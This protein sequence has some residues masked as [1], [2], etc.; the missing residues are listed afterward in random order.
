VAVE[1]SA[2][3]APHPIN[4][5]VLVVDDEPLVRWSLKERL[6]REGCRVLE[7]GT[8]RAAL[9]LADAA[10]DAMVLDYRLPDATG[11]GVLQAVTTLY[12]ETQVILMTAYSTLENAADAVAL[13]A[14]DYV[15]KPFDVDAVAGMVREAVALRRLLQE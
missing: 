5:T 10:V 14:F 9:A 13:G 6:T 11:L 8:A 3:G 2:P 15:A 1:K 7:A 4:A 12:P